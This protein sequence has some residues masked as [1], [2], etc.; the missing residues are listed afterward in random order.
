MRDIGV[1]GVQTCALPILLAE[2][3][4]AARGLSRNPEH[5]ADV[6]ADGGV[7]VVCDLEHEDVGPHVR[8]AGA[9]VFAAGAGP[10]SG[11]ER[12]RTLDYGG[13]VAC[14]EA[15]EALGVARFVMVSS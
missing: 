14:I 12:K 7:P 8:G 3:G 1:T 9:V 6:E 13:A 2:R 10:G 5:A 15:A 11:P 4:L